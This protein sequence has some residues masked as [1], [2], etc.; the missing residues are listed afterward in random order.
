[1]VIKIYAPAPSTSS[2][3]QYN[4]R[5]VAEEKASV[6]SSSRIADVADPMKTFI[7]YENGSLKTEKMSFHA[8]INPSVTDKL[9]DAQIAELV[10]KWMQKMGYAN[11]PYLL[12]KHTDTGR[13]H[14]HLVSVRVDENGR[15]IPDFQ[16]RKR[17]QKAM[18][19]LSEKFDFEI[20]K[21][22]TQRKDTKEKKTTNPYEGFD[23][24]AGDFA[25]Q[26]ERIA[27]LA[28]TFYFKKPEQFDLI[29]E[30]LGIQV[31]HQ[32]DGSHA[33]IGLDP[34]THKPVTSP[35]QDSGIRFPSTE[36]IQKRADTCKG[37]VK[38]REKQKVANAVRIAMSPKKGI[39][40][41]LH[42]L[43]YLARWGIYTKFAKTADGKIFGV[44][45]VDMKNKCVFKASDVPGIT[46]SQFE[47]ARAHIWAKQAKATEHAATKTNGATE[48]AGIQTDTPVTAA[49]ICADV[50]SIAITAFGSERSRQNEEE[51]EDL[52]KG[53]SL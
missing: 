9:T 45:F 51:D 34:K 43:R 4:E 19:E 12:Y 7:V 28:M 5:K 2:A 1:M 26:V 47:E 53:R 27:N 35:I 38:T 52:D 49:E 50:A 22:T 39:K 42:T 25:G 46:A 29:M 11:Q 17:S 10:R 15:K 40:T 16:E 36:A 14:Y 20:G 8:S 23:P 13:I 3:V 32:V 37:Q 31:L 33:F 24:K 48:R 44:T 6:I 21:G 30:S 18:Q 41:E